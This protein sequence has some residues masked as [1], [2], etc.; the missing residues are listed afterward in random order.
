MR[1]VQAVIREQQLEAVVERLLLI[2]VRGLTVFMARGAGRAGGQQVFRGSAC[3]VDF[4]PKVVLE[5]YGPDDEADA[6]VR[7]IRHRATT[8]AIGDGKIF[9]QTIDDAVRIRTGERG[10]DAV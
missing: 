5:W 6:V 7:A 4:A 10:I 8:G 2:G 9:V 3:R 1:K